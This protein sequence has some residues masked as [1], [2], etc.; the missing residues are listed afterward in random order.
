MFCRIKA[1]ATAKMEAAFKQYYESK[2][3]ETGRE[4]T[5]IQLCDDKQQEA[6]SFHFVFVLDES[7]S[8]SSHWSSLQEAYQRF[9]QRRNDDQ[10]GDDYF[11]VVLFDSSA[12][13]ICRQQ[14]YTNTPK[15]L[16][17]LKNG[18]TTY[19]AGLEQARQ[20]IDADRTASSV[21]MIFMSDGGNCGGIGPVE[22]IRQFK[23]NYNTNHRFVCHT[24]G[25][26]SG[27][28]PGSSAYQLLASMASTGGGQSYS[29]MNSIELKNV[30]GTIAANSTANNA[31][32][33]R[34]S[35]I[36]AREISVKIMVDY[37]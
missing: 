35:S 19:S 37:L 13:T 36:L 32:V 6:Q 14:N 1:T 4:F 9:L 21:V 25:F 22:L 12:R 30:F 10:G 28:A 18:G 20:A 29:A 33:D 17:P 3:D 23:Q 2:K 16:P 24:I 11:T 34:F 5:S 26:G 7:G 15:N 31:L 27:I 8:M